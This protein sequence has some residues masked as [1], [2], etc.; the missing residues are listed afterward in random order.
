MSF[1]S[2]FGLRFKRGSKFAKWIKKNHL[3]L[4]GFFGRKKKPVVH[5]R[6]IMYDDIN[7]SLIP[8]NAEAVAG[9]IGGR[10]PTYPK[11]VAG[12]PKAKHMSIAVA[13]NYNADCLDVEPGDAAPAQAA[14]WIRQQAKLRAASKEGYNTN[15]PV[16][17]TNASHGQALIDSLTAA[18]LVYGKDYLWWSAHYNPAQGEHFCSPKCGFGIK[19]TAHGT[20]FTDAANKENLDE[21]ILSYAFFG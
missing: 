17:Y 9:Y 8:K 13:A 16:V 19:V 20:Q 14:G 4:I 12:W 6:V 7:V 18:G 21:S 2:E 3:V 11:V 15:K 5:T 10:W 1:A